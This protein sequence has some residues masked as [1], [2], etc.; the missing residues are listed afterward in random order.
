ML[1]RFTVSVCL[2]TRVKT[3][4]CLPLEE[5]VMLCE[6]P[7]AMQGPRG[8][9]LSPRA[10][11]LRPG[12]PH[13]PLRTLKLEEVRT[14]RDKSQ[15]GDTMA[16]RPRKG[17]RN[18]TPGAEEPCIW[19]SRQHWLHVGAGGPLGGTWC[20]RCRPLHWQV[21]SHWLLRDRPLR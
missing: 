16:V 18:A 4:L 5:A 13:T 20:S 9:G 3:A 15:P 1:K 14:Y 10:P 8:R 17:E 2:I 12:T 7:A 11:P 21:M 19:G 6:S